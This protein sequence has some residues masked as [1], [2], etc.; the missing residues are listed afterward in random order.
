MTSGLDIP[1]DATGSHLDERDRALTTGAFA[2]LGA[3]ALPPSTVAAY[4][5]LLF[6]ADAQ[7]FVTTQFLVLILLYP[8]AVAYLARRG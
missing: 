5:S 8:A 7:G 2:V 4:A 6:D 1:S 3:V